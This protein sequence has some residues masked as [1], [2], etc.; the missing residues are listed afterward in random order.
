MHLQDKVMCALISNQI[1]NGSLKL[2]VPIIPYYYKYLDSSYP[3]A[4]Q[5]SELSAC[6]TATQPFTLSCKILYV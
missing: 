5:V 3:Y 6:G 4:N 1:L 2:N